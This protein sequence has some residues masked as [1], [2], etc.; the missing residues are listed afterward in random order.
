MEALTIKVPMKWNAA[1]YLVPH[2]YVFPVHTAKNGLAVNIDWCLQLR[3]VTLP[4]LS[5][6]RKGGRFNFS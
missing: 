5:N 2:I 1:C 3:C 4:P 6:F